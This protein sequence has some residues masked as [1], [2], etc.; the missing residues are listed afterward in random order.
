[1]Q[2]GVSYEDVSIRPDWRQLLI[3]E[4]LS[5]LAAVVLLIVGGLD[6]VPYHSVFFCVALALGFKVYYRIVYLRTM[7]YTITGEQLVYEHG[8]FSRS[9][10][11]IELYR[12]VD[13]DEKRSFLQLILGLKTVV[14]HSGDR[15]MPKL[16]I[17]GIR[18]QNDIVTPLRER[19]SYNR[20]R[21]NIHE[22][23]NY[24]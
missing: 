2:T 7:L 15:T 9:R 6:G 16:L 11:Y 12:I 24:R 23:A 18:E 17:I 5:I 10:D 8:V 22:F 19:V 4:L 3:D 20:K 1:M 13:F 21:M 14:V